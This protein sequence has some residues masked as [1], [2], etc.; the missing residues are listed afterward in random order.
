MSIQCRSAQQ[1]MAAVSFRGR[2]LKGR[3][4]KGRHDAGDETVVLDYNKETSENVFEILRSVVKKDVSK[5]KKLGYYNAFVRL[6]YRYGNNFK[7]S[8]S[9]VEILCCL[10]LGLLHE[11]KE[12][13]AASL[14]A[15]RYFCQDTETIEALLTLHIDYFIIRALDISIDNEIERIHA[16]RLIRKIIH[17]SP[18]KFPSSLVHVMVSIANDGTADRDKMV[19]TCLAILC[20]LALQNAQLVCQCGGIAAITKN[21]LHTRHLPRIKESLLATLLY[22]INHPRTRHYFKAG[23]DLEQ[24]LAP[25]TDCHDNPTTDASDFSPSDEKENRFTASQGAL[26][27]IMR[28]WPGLV[29]LCKPDGSA[30][31]SL[32]GVLYLRNMETRV[33]VPSLAVTT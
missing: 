30:L 7:V 26:A 2:N 12:M 1:K 5:T 3:R 9:K 15:L 33:C 24:L 27:T 29:S 13:R 20:E 31:Q 17:V 23:V 28:S 4:I 25:F 16:L 22:L 10:R 21:V 32:L 19:R 8:Y 18:E 6:C 14:R 11:A